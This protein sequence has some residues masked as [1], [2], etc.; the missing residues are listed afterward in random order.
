M[1][2][3]CGA[4]LRFYLITTIIPMIVK[5]SVT[6]KGTAHCRVLTSE[7]R[8]A[9]FWLSDLSVVRTSERVMPSLSVTASI[10]SDPN[11]SLS[12]TT[13]GLYSRML[14][15]V[16]FDRDQVILVREGNRP[17]REVRYLNDQTAV[18]SWIDCGP[19][20]STR[21]LRAYFDRRPKRPACRVGPGPP[22]IAINSR[23][24]AESTK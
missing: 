12:W 3:Q 15:S 5:P 13:V 17:W 11:S 2:E 14:Q 23:R 7:A 24:S 10:S 9:T 8:A 4:C 18:I 6:I 21:P 22:S 19:V 1:N 20:V 16:D